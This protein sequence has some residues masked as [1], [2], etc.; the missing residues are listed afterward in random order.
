V[1]APQ[2]VRLVATT[3]LLGRL[4]KGMLPLT[5]VLMVHQA[6]N[7]YATAGLAAALL[8]A[9]DAISAPAQGWLT[10]R[11]GRDRVLIPSAALHVAALGGVLILIRSGT[12]IGVM[13]AAF[14]AGIGMPPISG[15][16]KAAWPK[17][18]PPDALAAAYVV[19]SLLQQSSSSLVRLWWPRPP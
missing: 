4:P 11:F 10:D 6:T 1:L 8:S 7:S 17:M 19:E 3:S 5:V 15:S 2:Q 14:V 9:G 12:L 13:A 16:I 18:A